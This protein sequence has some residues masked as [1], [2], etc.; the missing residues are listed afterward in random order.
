MRLRRRAST[1]LPSARSARQ[2][3]ALCASAAAASSN[4]A[5]PR[6]PC[7]R[8]AA[9]DCRSRLAASRRVRRALRALEA[10][11]REQQTF[12]RSRAPTRTARSLD[13]RARAARTRGHAPRRA[14]SARASRLAPLARG[15]RP[16]R[17]SSAAARAPLELALAAVKSSAPSTPNPADN[18][19]SYSRVAQPAVDLGDAGVRGRP[20][21]I[22]R[23]RLAVA[24]ERRH[25]ARRARP[26]TSRAA[27]APAPRAS[28]RHARDRPTLPRVSARS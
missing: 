17:A 5:H 14:R 11:L 27:R 24:R 26:P 20:M 7:R 12:R 2:P 4:S 18:S 15:R 9:W 16:P 22:D 13:P 8:T 10:R 25:R 23:E 21:R 19:R 1:R 28:V 3:R 6:A